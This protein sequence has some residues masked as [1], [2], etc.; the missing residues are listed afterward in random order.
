VKSHFTHTRQAVLTLV[1][2]HALLGVL[3]DL[4]GSIKSWFGVSICPFLAPWRFQEER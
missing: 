3:G 2:V 1:I 4:G